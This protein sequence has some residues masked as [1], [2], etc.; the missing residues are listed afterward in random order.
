M[1]S[2]ILRHAEKVITAAARKEAA[3]KRLMSYV[4]SVVERLCRPARVPGRSREFVMDRHE[5]GLPPHVTAL[6]RQT[7]R[8]GLHLASELGEVAELLKIKLRDEETTVGDASQESLRGK[9]GEGLTDDRGRCLPLGCDIGCLQLLTTGKFPVQD[10][11]SNLRQCVGQ[12]LHPRF[13]FV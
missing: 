7:R 10:R 13:P 3:V 11:V 5:L 2:E 4:P 1:I 8:C 12:G 9:L 6:H